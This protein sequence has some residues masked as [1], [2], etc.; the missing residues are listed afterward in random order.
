M[1]SCFGNPSLAEWDSR[2][3]EFLSRNYVVEKMPPI[4]N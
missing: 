3:E 2:N 1:I 4:G